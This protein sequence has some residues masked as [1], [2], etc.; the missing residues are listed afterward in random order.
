MLTGHV[1]GAAFPG[2]NPTAATV[3]FTLDTPQTG[4]DGI[5]LI[6]SEGGGPAGADLGGFLAVGELEVNSQIPEPASL[7]LLA[8]AG[9]ALLRRRRR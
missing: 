6:G 3:N 8:L 9:L 5:R 4:I 2:F 7:S 1:I